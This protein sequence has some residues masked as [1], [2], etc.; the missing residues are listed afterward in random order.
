MVPPRSIVAG[1]VALV[2]GVGSVAFAARGD[3]VAHAEYSALGPTLIF[4]GGGA[5]AGNNN[6]TSQ[7][8]TGGAL[9]YHPALPPRDLIPSDH[10][11]IQT[12]ELTLPPSGNATH[13]VSVVERELNYP[14]TSQRS[15][16][17][18]GRNSQT[19]MPLSWQKFRSRRGM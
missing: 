18:G 13:N 6:A 7:I 12:S 3:E 10:R 4:A 15:F 9:P 14:L 19:P 1:S 16:A 17:G 11:H 2:M 5:G 8:G